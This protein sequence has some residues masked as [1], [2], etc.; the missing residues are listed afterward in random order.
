[1]Q[2]RLPS[3]DYGGISLAALGL[4]LPLYLGLGALCGLVALALQNAIRYAEEVW[5]EN[6]AIGSVVPERLRPA[7]CGALAG[8]L[9]V[10]CQPVLFNGY[11]TLNSILQD[12]GG[13]AATLL[14]YTLLKIIA[15]A[16]AVGAGLVGG[17]FA[18]SLFLGA[19]AGSAYAQIASQL[20]ELIGVDPNFLT[21]PACATVGAASV[22]AAV[23]RAPL[24]AAMLLFELTRDY[25][26]VLP[27]VASAGV[28][29]LVVELNGRPSKYRES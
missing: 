2:L 25:D 10:Y 7:A 8:A 15:T 5:D 27:L 9:G 12:Q 18:P 28:A 17:L 3:P 23:F 29:A 20:T 21:T 14:T 11:A 4:E 22:L 24:T 26:V 13:D 19:T 16:A 1:M 6:G